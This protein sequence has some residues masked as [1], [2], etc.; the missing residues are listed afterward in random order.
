[1]LFNLPGVIG[2]YGNLILFISKFNKNNFYI[3]YNTNLGLFEIK[4]YSGYHLNVIKSLR[5]HWFIWKFNII[6]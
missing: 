5:Y 4:F 3:K 2:L 1:M 6:Y